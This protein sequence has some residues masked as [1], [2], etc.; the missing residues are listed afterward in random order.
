VLSARTHVSRGGGG[1]VLSPILGRS[2]RQTITILQREINVKVSSLGGESGK[3]SFT[4]STPNDRP[5]NLPEHCTAAFKHPV[6]VN[7]HYISLSLFSGKSIPWSLWPADNLTTWPVLEG[8]AAQSQLDANLCFVYFS[9]TY[10]SQNLRTEPTV[11]WVDWSMR[12]VA[13]LFYDAC[14]V[15]RLYTVHRRVAVYCVMLCL[16][17]EDAFVITCVANL[18]EVKVLYVQQDLR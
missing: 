2:P 11:W 3:D 7:S 12:L 10:R 9:S 13:T 8:F 17:S 6:Y 5:N 1:A 18:M 16:R 15:T 14:S 4:F